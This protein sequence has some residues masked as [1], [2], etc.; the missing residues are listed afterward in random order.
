MFLSEKVRTAGS[1]AI[2]IRHSANVN[3]FLGALNI[4]LFMS[5]FLVIYNPVYLFDVHSILRD[6]ITSI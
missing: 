3:C 1:N 6:V 4:A 5:G 2:Q